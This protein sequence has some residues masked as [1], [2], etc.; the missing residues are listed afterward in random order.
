MLVMAYWPQTRDFYTLLRFATCFTA[1][2]LIYVAISAKKYGWIVFFAFVILLFNPLTD[3]RIRRETWAILDIGLAAVL[4][5]SILL[6]SERDRP[7]SANSSDTG[8]VPVSADDESNSNH[9]TGKPIFLKCASR[10]HTLRLNPIHFWKTTHCPRCKTVVDPIR[11]RR[12][13]IRASLVFSSTP[14]FIPGEIKR[15]IIPI[16]G[17]IAVIVVFSTAVFWSLRIENSVASEPNKAPANAFSGS[18]EP[19]NVLALHDPTPRTAPANVLANVTPTSSPLQQAGLNENDPGTANAD[20]DNLIAEDQPATTPTPDIVRYQT[21]ANLFRS[22]SGGGRGSLRI[23]NGTESDAVAKL[24]DSTT[25]KTYRLVYV[26]ASSV[27]NVGSIGSGSY[28]LKFSLG[29]DFDKSSGKF[30]RAQSFTK[31][32]EIMNFV[33]T[34]NGNEVRWNDHEVTLNPVIGGNARTSRISESEF[35]DY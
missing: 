3:F 14:Q 21:G 28:L 5:L 19:S 25:G 15:W 12:L 13:F 16:L 33:E 8:E 22:D 10:E 9:N 24:V 29:F 35:E 23:S 17:V 4:I 11:L 20:L 26:R 27:A 7:S 2:Y 34:R 18:P 30:L 31:F 32:D 6:L 1:V